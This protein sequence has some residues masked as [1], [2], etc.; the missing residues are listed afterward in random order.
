MCFTTIIWRF[1]RKSACVR[2]AFHLVR[3]G[4]GGNEGMIVKAQRRPGLQQI[5][6]T[7]KQQHSWRVCKFTNCYYKRD[8]RPQWGK[9][10]VMCVSA[11]G[12]RMREGRW[13]QWR[14][15]K[16]Q[17]KTFTWT[18]SQERILTVLCIILCWEGWSRTIYYM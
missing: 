4:D 2:R 15:W 17:R 18:S 13:W 5:F 16:Y 11:P 1:C 3:Y 10:M 9:C 8:R 14:R 6:Y 7:G 12:N